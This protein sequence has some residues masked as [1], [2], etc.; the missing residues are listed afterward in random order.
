MRENAGAWLLFEVHSSY[1]PTALK[2]IGLVVP[3]GAFHH[4]F[5]KVQLLGSVN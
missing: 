4:S 5:G 1:A 2:V 3:E